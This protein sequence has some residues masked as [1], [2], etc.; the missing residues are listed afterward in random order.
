LWLA[1]VIL[2][3]KEPTRVNTVFENRRKNI[4]IMNN[5]E[6]P[7]TSVQSRVR[8]HT[9]A[10]EPDLEFPL[11]SMVV[12][13]GT[14]LWYEYRTLGRGLFMHQFMLDTEVLP[15]ENLFPLS[16]FSDTQEIIFPPAPVEAMCSR[17]SKLKEC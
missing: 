2:L 5:E 11:S 3:G 13:P 15:Q 6:D 7:V 12:L 4:F 8:G 9:L 16:I 10:G 14:D 17:I 1:T